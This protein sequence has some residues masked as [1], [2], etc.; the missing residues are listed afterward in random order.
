ME[1]YFTVIR[2]PVMIVN[3]AMHIVNKSY[4][5]VEDPSDDKTSR[6]FYLE[7]QSIFTNCYAF[8][9]ELQT[10]VG[11][12]GAGGS[13]SRFTPGCVAGAHIVHVAGR[14]GAPVAEPRRA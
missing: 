7:T 3:V 4:E 14:S 5:D 10:L 11:R 2:R 12:S 6:D 1:E 13:R 9:T 8:N